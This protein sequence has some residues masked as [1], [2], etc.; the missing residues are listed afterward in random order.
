MFAKEMSLYCWNLKR[1][2]L[3]KPKE[4]NLESLS[5]KNLEESVVV[6]QL[7]KL[8][9]R[10]NFEV[11]AFNFSCYVQLVSSLNSTFLLTITSPLTWLYSLYVLD[12]EKY[13]MEMHL[14]YL[15]FCY[16]YENLPKDNNQKFLSGLSKASCHFKLHRVSDSIL[17]LLETNSAN[18]LLCNFVLPKID[19][20]RHL[21]F[22]KLQTISTVV[23]FFSSGT[24]VFAL[25]CIVQSI[26]CELK[27]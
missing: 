27:D 10:W 6:L 8:H 26:L 15:S 13:P 4:M 25:V 20:G 2:G 24:P 9:L 23:R 11:Q 3:G 18:R 12:Q 7:L 14:T 17:P 16:D 1:W 19:F 22:S 21:A 5:P